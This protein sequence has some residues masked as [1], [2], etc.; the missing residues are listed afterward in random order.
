M[1]VNTNTTT[2][3]HVS[4]VR[5]VSFAKPNDTQKVFDTHCKN[6]AESIAEV[7]W[8]SKQRSREQ[9]ESGHSWLA[10]KCS[11]HAKMVDNR[12]PVVARS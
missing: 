7:V 1:K 5:H 2:A 8:L 6:K 12:L 11:S 9:T 4:T 3:H 10:Q